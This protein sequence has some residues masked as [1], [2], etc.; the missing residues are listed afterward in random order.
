[1]ARPEFGVVFETCLQKR[2]QL[3]PEDTPHKLRFAL[4]SARHIGDRRWW[5][6]RWFAAEL[7]DDPCLQ[8]L[9]TAI[10]QHEVKVSRIIES[11]LRELEA[12]GST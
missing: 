7:V 2:A 3:G 11:M 4:F 6:S 10:T 9:A 1:M 5:E 8:T 12:L